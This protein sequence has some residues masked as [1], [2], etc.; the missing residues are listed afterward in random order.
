M[1]A[2]QD[3]NAG[4]GKSVDFISAVVNDGNN[5]A[6]YTI[7]LLGNASG[8]ILADPSTGIPLLTAVE[9]AQ[10]SEA[11]LFENVVVRERQIYLTLTQK[12]QDVVDR[13]TR[14]VSF[15][16]QSG[17][18][19]NCAASVNRQLPLCQAFQ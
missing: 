14:L 7:T 6:N 3:A 9:Y 18:L 5:G 11:D 4:T 1:F 13:E 16:P 12:E 2:Y 19:I 10:R 15:T 17:V 8:E